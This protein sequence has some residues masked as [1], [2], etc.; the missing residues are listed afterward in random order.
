MLSK[1][2][3]YSIKTNDIIL[4][5]QNTNI[6][7]KIKK[8]IVSRL[9]S[10]KKKEYIKAFILGDNSDISNE[11]INSYRINGITH[12]FAISGMHVALLSTLILYILNKIKNSN[13]NY[14]FVILFLIFYMFLTNFTPSVIR[15]TILFI[16]ITFNKI[17]KLNLST[18]RL[19]LYILC[20]NLI[21]NPYNVYNIGFQFIY[22]ISFYLIL[23]NKLIN[24]FKN[25]FIKVFITSFISFLTSIPI[26][27][28]N[29]FSIN[30]MTIINVKNI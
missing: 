9:D 8:Y 27:I 1:N 10:I 6:L 13:A 7:Y 4:L 17:L 24:K 14:V 22:I 21:I 5:K 12:L 19:L 3:Y 2:T 16:F 26:L 18:I 20:T 28:N 30:I 15:A 11:V 23:F 25:Y 29:Y